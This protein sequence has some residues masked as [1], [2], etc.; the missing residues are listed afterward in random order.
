MA[1]TEKDRD[2]IV[3][4]IVDTVQTS[5]TEL[6]DTRMLR[7]TAEDILPLIQSPNLRIYPGPKRSRYLQVTLMDKHDRPVHQMRVLTA[8]LRNI[9]LNS[10]KH[11]PGEALSDGQPKAI[12]GPR[13]GRAMV[14][15]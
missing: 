6:E 13:D 3:R 12:V 14:L 7:M 10:Y 9:L 1:L 4:L 2:D 15:D 5:L 8:E 11:E